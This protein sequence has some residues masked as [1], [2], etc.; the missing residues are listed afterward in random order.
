MKL[1]GGVGVIEIETAPAAQKH[2]S[3]ESGDGQAGEYAQPR[4][5]LLGHDVSRGI[6]GDGAKSKNSGGM[7][8]GDDETEQ[9][10]MPRGAPRADQVGRYD[11][12][13]VARF[14]RVQ[15][16]QPEGDEGGCDQE[17]QTQAAGSDQ[18]SERAAR[19]RLLI[20]LQVQR[21]SHSQLA[22]A[23]SRCVL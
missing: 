7:R 21:R 8:G 6:E 23:R 5:E 4:V 15:R 13:A 22:W 16:A 12:L 11:R 2:V 20:G 14:Q 19:G 9:Q 10:G 1:T 17:P 18:L 3:A